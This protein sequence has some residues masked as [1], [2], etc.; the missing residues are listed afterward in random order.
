MRG[1]SGASK[2]LSKTGKGVDSESF[3]GDAEDALGLGVAKVSGAA[4]PLELHI[5]HQYQPLHLK[6]KTSSLESSTCTILGKSGI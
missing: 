2:G 1:A 4:V 6:N 5:I 3:S